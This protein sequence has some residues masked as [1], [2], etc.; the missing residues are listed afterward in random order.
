MQN[1]FLI[2]S[3]INEKIKW[4]IKAHGH[5]SLGGLNLIWTYFEFNNKKEI[6][7]K[8]HEGIVLFENFGNSNNL[9]KEDENLKDNIEE[10]KNIIEKEDIEC[11]KKEELLEIMKGV[12]KNIERIEKIIENPNYEEKFKLEKILFSTIVQLLKRYPS[13]LYGDIIGNKGKDIGNRIKINVKKAE[14]E[15]MCCGYEIQL[16]FFNLL[17]NAIDAIKEKGNIYIELDYKEEKLKIDIS[18]DGDLINEEDVKKILEKKEFST[19]GRDHGHGLRIIDNIIEKYN[20]TMNIIS[21]KEKKLV[22]FSIV[23]PLKT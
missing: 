14:E 13:V 1:N 10:I 20:G 3:N 21:N 9:K 12:K 16:L 18:D 7:E 2:S 5:S 15:V 6:A 4:Y 23:L 17:S 19:K 22:T 11:N 8:I